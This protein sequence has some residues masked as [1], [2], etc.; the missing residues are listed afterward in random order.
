MRKFS[1]TPLFAQVKEKEI[2][3]GWITKVRYYSCKV[4]VVCCTLY[5]SDSWP[6]EYIV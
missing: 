6:I 4:Y 2:M 1:S 3:K 5:L